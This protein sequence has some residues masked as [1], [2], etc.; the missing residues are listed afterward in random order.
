MTVAARATTSRWITPI[1]V[2]RRPWPLRTA[3]ERVQVRLVV[4]PVTRIQQYGLV[5]DTSASWL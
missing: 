1:P 3:S 5:D 2:V 4:A